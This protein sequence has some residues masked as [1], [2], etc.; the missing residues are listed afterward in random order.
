MKFKTTVILFAVFLVL[1]AFVLFF[2]YKGKG[3]KDEEEKLLALSSDDAQKVTFKKEDETISFQKDE[4]GEWL[5]T[6]PLEAKA[7]KYEVDRLADD[8]SDLKIERVVEEEPEELA[9]GDKPLV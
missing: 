6:E 8:F 3:E 4:E 1:L 5:I 7:D 9:K 2:E